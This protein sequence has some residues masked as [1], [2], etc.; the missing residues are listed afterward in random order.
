VWTS[1]DEYVAAVCLLHDPA[2]DAALEASRAAGLPAISV[3][4]PQG[5]L[6]HL[7]ARMVGARRMLEIGTLG[8][9]S[10]IW[11]ARA[12]PEGGRLVTL[13]YEQKH[14]DVAR[15]NIARAGLSDR[16]E[17]RVGRA[18]ETLPGLE[19]EGAGPFDL[20]FIDADKTGY[21][22][23]WPWALRL[24][25]PG[26]VIV[27]DNVVRDGKVADS[28]SSDPNVQGV[29][30]YLALVGAERRVTSTVLQ[31]VGAKG[32]DGLSIAIVQ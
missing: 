2:L 5:K 31:T 24:A 4:A 12:L 26:T 20:V 19:T 13:E 28:Q 6:L 16:V 17:I 29:R 1:V 3:S 32:Y 14:A 10:A 22:D 11:L 25:R 18:I 23:Y 8:G 21:P 30:R 7:I 9:Y 27:A 15:A